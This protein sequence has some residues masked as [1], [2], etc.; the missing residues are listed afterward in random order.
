MPVLFRLLLILTTLSAFSPVASAVTLKIATLAP[1]GTTWM[2]ELKAAGKLIAEETDNRVKLKFFPGG[3]MGTDQS[4]LRKIRV[5]QLHGG[6]LSG[7]ALSLVYKGAQI[8]S[9]PFLFQSHDEVREARI[10]LDPIIRENVEKKGLVVLGISE[11]GFAH[12]F[13]DKEIRNVS[14]L[15]GQKVWV[16]EEDL[17]TRHAFKRA[18][19]SPIPLP[20]ADVYTGLQTGLLDTVGVNPTGAIALQ[21][22]TKVKHMVNRPLLFLMGF[23]VVDKRTFKK[24]SADDQAIVH[25]IVDDAFDRLNVSNQTDDENAKEALQANG[26]EFVDVSDADYENWRGIARSALDELA[27]DDVFDNELRELVESRLLEYRQQHGS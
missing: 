26:I 17:I 23:M 8:Y 25:R 12:L 24:L 27:A 3:V 4:V 7:G 18:D 21:W 1:N 22:H 2:K 9:L 10:I 6:A 11:G 14:D 15:K 16:P 5:G 20:V 19:V 13:S